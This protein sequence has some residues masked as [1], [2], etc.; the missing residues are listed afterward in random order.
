MLTTVEEITIDLTN[1]YAHFIIIAMKFTNI[2]VVG[3][4]SRSPKSNASDEEG[5]KMIGKNSKLTDIEDV[6]SNL[7]MDAGIPSRNGDES[8]DSCKT[9]SVFFVVVPRE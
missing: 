1:V 2:K 8:F 3:G 9:I 4:D 5:Y 7:D 6:Q